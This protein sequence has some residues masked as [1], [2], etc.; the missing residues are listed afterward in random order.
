MINADYLQ[1]IHLTGTG[2]D[3]GAA[4]RGRHHA[5]SSGIAELEVQSGTEDVRFGER[6]SIVGTLLR[7]TNRLAYHGLD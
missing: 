4:S 2:A 6:H 7:L 1:L 5:R 3:A